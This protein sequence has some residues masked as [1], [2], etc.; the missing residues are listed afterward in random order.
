MFVIPKAGLSI[1]DPQQNNVLP[2]EG[3]NVNQ[4]HPYYWE[5]HRQDGSVKI[6]IDPDEI[7]AAQATLE[8]A[9]AKRAKDADDARAKAEAEAQK[10]ADLRDGV[11][12]KT[13]PA[14]K[15]VSK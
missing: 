14:A 13:E 5:R 9:D 4:D 6:L 7:K 12:A 10:A 8:K 1:V 3:R 2:P 11:Q 15:P